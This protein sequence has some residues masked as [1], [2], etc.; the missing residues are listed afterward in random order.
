[1][2]FAQVE[3][4]SSIVLLLATCIALYLANSRLAPLYQAVLRLPVKAGVGGRVFIWPV[5]LWIND[6]LMALFFLMV[7]LEVKREILVGELASFRR[8]ILPGGDV[9]SWP[10]F[11][12][13]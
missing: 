5:E 9:E 4:S 11:Y 12:G 1:M 6:V 7:G 10:R 8:A 2:R 3:S 13:W